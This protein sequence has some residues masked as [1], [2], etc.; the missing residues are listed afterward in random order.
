MQVGV[1]L[2]D[3]DTHHCRVSEASIHVGQ[4]ALNLKR[5]EPSVRDIRLDVEMACGGARGGI[6][7]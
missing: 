3:I 7:A 5:K 1:E 6:G 2:W 4:V